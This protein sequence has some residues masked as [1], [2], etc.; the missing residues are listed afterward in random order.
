M[1]EVTTTPLAPAVKPAKVLTAVAAGVAEATVTGYGLVEAVAAPVQLALMRDTRAVTHLVVP[2]AQVS[3]TA[4]LDLHRV[5]AAAAEVGTQ[6]KQ[7]TAAR[8]DSLSKVANVAPP[9]WAVQAHAAQTQRQVQSIQ[10]QEVAA[11]ASMEVEE[12]T[13]VALV[14]PELL[15]CD[16]RFPP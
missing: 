7:Q 10:V 14:V 8:I 1:A 12:I 6:T 2:A 11:V 9:W 13:S 4:L 15:L 3:R 16:T 5:T